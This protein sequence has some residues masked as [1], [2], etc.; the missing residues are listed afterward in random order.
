[1][2]HYIVVGMVTFTA[3]MIIRDALTLAIGADL[4][5]D[6][7]GYWNAGQ[8]ILNGQPLYFD[9]GLPFGSEVYLFA[10]W[11]A[12]VW[13]PMTLLP[14]EPVM[15]SWMV[16]MCF[17]TYWAASPLFREGTLSSIGLGCIL[18]Y[19]LAW[20]AL[21][22]NVMP[23]LVG[24]LIHAHGRRQFPVV[25][26]LAASLKVLPVLYLWPYVVERQWN[27]VAIGVGIMGILWS[28][29]LLYGI[30][31]YPTGY[32]PTMSLMQVSGWLWAGVAV[33]AS[34]LAFALRHSKY[35][36]LTTTAAILAIY[37]RVHLHYIGLFGVG[38]ARLIPKTV[39]QASDA[40]RD[41]SSTSRGTAT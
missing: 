19:A 20:G 27:H 7:V 31:G 21:W 34:L 6:A 36:W 28:P 38:H 29:A 25:V 8:H 2:R 18:A 10:P 40:D 33:T 24:A 26:G 32:M 41:S 16:L 30:S 39:S 14:R 9:Q 15:L 22:A 12:W 11:F 23:L 13:A 4:M 17:A 1:M 5:R 37:P 3:S 35:R